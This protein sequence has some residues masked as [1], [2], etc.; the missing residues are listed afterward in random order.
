MSFLPIILMF[1]LFAFNVPIAYSLITST[2]FYFL[3]IN[4]TMPIQ[5]VLQRMVS[6]SESFPLLAIPFFVTAGS[7]MN[8]SGISSRLMKLA[9]VLVGHVVGGLGQVNVLLSILMGGLS[10]SS[11]ADTAMQCKILVPEMV[12]RGYSK[13]FS[14]AVT[15]TSS[16]ITAII[17]PGINLIIFGFLANV[18]V[19]KMFIAGIIPGLLMGTFLMIVV[20]II[21]RKR[22]YPP[23][24]DKRASFIE[25]LEQVK[26]SIWALLLPLGII[27]GLRVGMFTPTEAGALA[28]FYS[29]I[30]GFFIYKE[31]KPKHLPAIIQETVQIT[32]VVMLIIVAASAFSYYMSWERI[33]QMASQILIDLSSN[34]YVFILL[35]NILLLVLG[36]FIEGTASLIILT[37]LLVPTAIQLG[38]DPVHFGIMMVMNICIG[39]VTPPFG[40][41][42]F[43]VCSILEMPMVTYIKEAMPF[44]IALLLV[45]VLVS[46]IPGIPLLLPNLIM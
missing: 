1:I 21:S 45:L 27:M 18:S 40:T 9:E 12:K 44:I 28:V 39:G 33:P 19:G 15:A 5:M 46:Y 26:V 30:V 23:S 2:L 24:R 25:V 13:G 35:V 10:G 36:M 41:M 8:Y 42:M 17:P 16:L 6:G 32:S 22:Q 4:D 38:I 29:L 31:L 3:F 14:G 43:V 37:P 7:I 11:N 20:A 34:K